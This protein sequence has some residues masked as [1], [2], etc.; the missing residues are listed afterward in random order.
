MSIHLIEFSVNSIPFLSVPSCC[1]ILSAFVLHQKVDKE[2]YEEYLSEELILAREELIEIIAYVQEIQ[3]HSGLETSYAYEEQFQ[4]G[5]M[6]IVKSWAEGE[7]FVTLAPKSSIHEGT[8]VK[9]IQRLEECLRDLR[10]AAKLVGD[11][12]LEAKMEEASLL[13]RRDIIFC[14][15]LYTT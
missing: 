3:D 6:H 13:V 11:T 10:G 14:A 5:L 7:S 15:S 8:I 4:Y 2:E 1:A 12:R 9:T